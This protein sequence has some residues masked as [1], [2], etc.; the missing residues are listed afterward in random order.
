MKFVKFFQN[1][2]NT[3][4][5]WPLPHCRKIYK[6]KV[7]HMCREHA[8]GSSK[9]DGVEGASFSVWGSM[10]GRPRKRKRGSMG[11]ETP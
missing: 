4:Y 6:F 9:V 2:K 3:S 7:Y 1:F 11:G 10:G 8:E 5:T